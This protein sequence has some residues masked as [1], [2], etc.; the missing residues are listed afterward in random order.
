M[1]PRERVMEAVNHCWSDRMPADF[2]SLPAVTQ[3][4]MAR[5]GLA[6]EEELLQHL[7]IDMR[8]VWFAYEQP[9]DE[10]QVDANGYVHNIWGLSFRPGLSIEE[11]ENVIR[12]FTEESSVDEVYAHPW[13]SADDVD[14]SGIF[15]QCER[16]YDTY[17]TYGGAWSPFFHEIG[18]LIGQENQLIW[19]STRP[20][21]LE[22]ITECVVNFE[23]EVSRRFLEACRGKLDI[24]YI[25]NDFGTQRGLYFSPAHYQRFIRPWIKKYFDLA[26][27][28]GCKV[29][30]HSCGSVRDLIPWFIE[31][32][33]DI[34]NP[35]QVRAAGMGLESLVADFGSKLAFHGG[36]DTQ[37]TL[38][39][40]SVQEVREQVLGYRALTREHGGY[41]LC[42]SQEFMADIPDDNILAMYEAP[43][44]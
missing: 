12:P 15:S 13:P 11:P 20:D 40:G 31:D 29:M 42:P 43:R 4:L 6:E 26:H 21:L 8:R 5:L 39:F 22:A 14:Y 35:I 28:Y 30:Q 36:V 27:D 7:G 24:M 25:G 37:H 9:I 3:R 2:Q 33:V 34:L 1:L 23:L 16:Y 38:P 18:W 44:E 32:G 41:I 10:S 19:M 17:A